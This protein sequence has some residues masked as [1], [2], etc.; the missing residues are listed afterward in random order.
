M[1]VSSIQKRFALTRSERSGSSASGESLMQPFLKW[2]GG[3][4]WL[5]SE[6]FRRNLPKF[7]RWIE[8]FVGGGAGFFSVLPQRALLSDANAD[9]IHTYRMMRDKPQDLHEALSRH[10]RLHSTE[11]YYR[12]RDYEPVCDISRAARF[13]YLNRTCWN[14]LYRVNR[15]GQFNVPIGTKSQVIFEHENFDEFSRVLKRAQLE[16]RD[17]EDTV[18]EARDGDVVFA[19]PPYTVKHNMNGF[20]KYNENIFS[21]ED[22]V[23]LSRSLSRAR[24]RGASIISTNAD[25]KSVRELY[26]DEF[27]LYPVYR[28]SVISGVAKGRS[29]ISEIL[30][31]S[32]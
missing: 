15:Q 13:I 14:G 32:L 20:V 28:S 5:F 7:D 11:H 10:H 6:E 31:S 12:V 22:Q 19:D 27:Y 16:I 2:A 30:I 23:R 4:R 18:D 26:K 8:P 9:L 3:K 1:E 25:H 29:R 17:F 21:W 24:D